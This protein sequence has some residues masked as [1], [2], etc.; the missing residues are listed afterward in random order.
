MADNLTDTYENAVLDWLNPGQTAPTRPTSPLTV[1]LL[2]AAGS[3]SAAGTE[4]VAGSGTYARQSVT[5]AAAS[6]G[7]TSNTNLL[8]WTN[9]P[10]VTV[11]AVAVYENGGTR[12]WHGALTASKTVN[13][14]DTFQI[15]IGDLDL[16]IG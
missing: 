14:G 8:S 10:G 13:L 15:A 12:V 2:T 16:A 5:L 3:D 4:V 11:A 7:A 6:G 1:A 9:M